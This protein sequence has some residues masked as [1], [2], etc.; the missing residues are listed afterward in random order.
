[1]ITTIIDDVKVAA[2][3][4]RMIRDTD[5]LK[6]ERVL[7][8]SDYGVHV[9]SIRTVKEIAQILGVPVYGRG[10]GSAIRAEA[11]AYGS[12]V[13][14]YAIGKYT[15][16]DEPVTAPEE[17]RRIHLTTPDDKGLPIEEFGAAENEEAA[18]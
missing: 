16:G 12:Q 2:K 9:N 14:S 8:A 4:A 1:M 10:R 13:F 11:P 15:L 6:E 3:A 7:S 17:C 18:S 5:G